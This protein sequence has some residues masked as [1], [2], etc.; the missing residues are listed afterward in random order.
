MSLRTREGSSREAY[1]QHFVE[2]G[3][4]VEQCADGNSPGSH[5]VSPFRFAARANGAERSP[6]FILSRLL[7]AYITGGTLTLI[8][9]RGGR[10]SYGDGN[11][12]S[13]AIRIKTKSALLRIATNAPLAIGESYMDG[14]LE[15][16]SG[17]LDN[18]LDLCT[19]AMDRLE[20][21][22]MMTLWRKLVRP[23]RALQQRNDVKSA[24]RNIASHYD[25]SNDLY[26]LFLD[27]D[28]QYSCAYFRDGAE[29]LD[30]AQLNKKRLIEA[31]LCLRPGM[32]VLDIG[33]GWGGLA[34]HLAR[35]VPQLRVTGLTLSQEQLDVA[36]QRA[37]EAGV[38]DRVS[39]CL[40]DYRQEAETYDRIVSVGMFEHV[41]TS[42]YPDFF[43]SVKRLLAPDGLAL[44]H[45]IGRMEPPTETNVWVRKYIF[46]GGYCPSLSEVM[47][48]IEEARL[49]VTDIEI[50]RLHYAKT[51]QAWSRRFQANRQRVKAF[52]GERFCKMWEFYLASAEAAFRHGRLFVF[53][54][55]IAKARDAA[56][57][58][59]DYLYGGPR[60]MPSLRQAQES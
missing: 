40:R 21:H 42:N 5:S 55:Q 48:P 50:L 23:F 16:E 19:T 4:A 8:D 30:V 2:C 32:R 52:S 54:A 17:T 45:A 20:V 13:V 36:R 25:L 28:W 56:P 53:Q 44:L 27:V 49:W 41:G 33:S 57:L 26:R 39:F 3:P 43:A 47:Q 11:G 7:R 60:A 46:P 29:N 31:K 9:P 34:I 10:F 14:D 6:P 15:I 1:D 51:L 38:A 59:R 12:P 35:A 37:L 24:K 58:T 18:F 22:P